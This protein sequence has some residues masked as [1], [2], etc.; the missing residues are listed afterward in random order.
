MIITHGFRENVA[1]DLTEQPGLP[2]L[3]PMEVSADALNRQCVFIRQGRNRSPV[4]Q[5]F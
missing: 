2:V 3:Q 4:I 5:V 1:S